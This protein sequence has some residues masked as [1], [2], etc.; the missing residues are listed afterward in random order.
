VTW[1]HSKESYRRTT[2]VKG[3]MSGSSGE[4]CEYK[5][6]CHLRCCAVLP[7]RNLPTF[8]RCKLPPLSPLT[9]RKYAYL[10]R[11]LISTTLHGATSQNTGILVILLSL[12]HWPRVLRQ[13]ASNF[14]S[15][16][17]S[18]PRN[19][20]LKMTRSSTPHPSAPVS[21]V[22]VLSW[23]GFVLQWCITFLPFWWFRS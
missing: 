11:W 19:F 13:F 7:G 9:W 17:P 12:H 1:K 20:R 16:L 21:V 8:Q 4:V 15:T 3:D 18:R 2:S 5:D 22:F 23:P 10:K 14:S 6:G